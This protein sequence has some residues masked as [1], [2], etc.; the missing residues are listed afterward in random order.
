MSQGSDQS[1]SV[2]AVSKG[3]NPGIMPDGRVW[4][5]C[6][7][8]YRSASNTSVDWCSRQLWSVLTTTDPLTH[9]PSPILKPTQ[10]PPSPARIS[11]TRPPSLI[12]T[13]PLPTSSIRLRS[14]LCRFVFSVM[15][16]IGWSSGGKWI[17]G[18]DPRV[19]F[20]HTLQSASQS[21]KL[22]KWDIR[23]FLRQ[24]M[25]CPLRYASKLLSLTVS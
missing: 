3:F 4:T 10:R 17:A 6:S 1:V 20:A 16:A 14:A 5:V 22:I 21:R 12:S 13:I 23:P 9:W 18:V 11:P 8:L 25:T 2:I 19:G 15:R 7:N 24:D